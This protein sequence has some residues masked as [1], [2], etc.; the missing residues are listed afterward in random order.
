[1]V[2]NEN[3]EIQNRIEKIRDLIGGNTEALFEAV[4]LSAVGRLRHTRG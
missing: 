1:M 4:S 3:T 2:L